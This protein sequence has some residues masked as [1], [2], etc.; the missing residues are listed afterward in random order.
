MALKNVFD[1]PPLGYTAYISQTNWEVPKYMG[2]DDSA[3]ALQMHRQANIRF[4]W[5]TDLDSCR[6]WLIE[7]TE[8]RLRSM[9]GGEQWLMP[10]APAGPPMDFS[11]RPRN[12]RA[13]GAAAVKPGLVQKTVAGIGAVVSW[14]G[15]GLQTVDQE[16]ANR[17]AE[18]CS[19]CDRNQR[20]EGMEKSIGT[21]GH[22]LHSIAEAKREMKLA[23][24]FDEKLHQCAACLCVTATKVWAPAEHVVKGITPEIEKELSEKC[25]I[26]PLLAE[27]SQ[28]S[29]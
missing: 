17:R 26:R 24:P 29:H 13:E 5:A 23:T 6:Q 4:G 19:T 15:S 2:L 11:S 12:R 18:I 14:L 25:W 27:K 20:L 8:A 10:G 16:T 1:I 28:V 21:V 22:V 9:P 7:Y 3:K